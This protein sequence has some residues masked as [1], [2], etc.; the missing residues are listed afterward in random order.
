MYINSG[1]ISL[2]SA[3]RRALSSLMESRLALSIER[4][5]VVA[6]IW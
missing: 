3:T 4:Y 5:M 6:I 1:G 2:P